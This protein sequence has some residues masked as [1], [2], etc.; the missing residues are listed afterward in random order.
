[1]DVILRAA[2]LVD[3]PDEVEQ[4]RV[5]ASRFV[6]APVAQEAVDLRETLRVEP[7]V[8]L[9]GDRRPL[10]GVGEE[11]FQRSIFRGSRGS[12]QCDDRGGGGRD[13][14]GL[15]NPARNRLDSLVGSSVEQARKKR[16]HRI[17]RHSSSDPNEIHHGAAE[18]SRRR[19]LARIMVNKD[20]RSR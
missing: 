13:C 16:S 10:A 5:H 6:P 18:T 8:A 1:M 4:A 2:A 15:R 14:G 12:G 11:Q 17:L 19:L 9:E 3:F 20:L 7:A